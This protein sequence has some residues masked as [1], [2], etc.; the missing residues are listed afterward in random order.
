MKKAVSGALL[1]AC[2]VVFVIFSYRS[3]FN[4]SFS[5]VPEA[6]RA[7]FAM[8]TYMTIHCYGE[9]AEEAAAAAEEEIERIEALL[10]AKNEGSDISQEEIA[11]LIRKAL[12]L[13]EETKGAFDPTVYPLTKLWGF[14]HAPEESVERHRTAPS[15]EEIDQILP[16][17][18][19]E[20]VQ[21]SAEGQE[22]DLGG[23]AKG[24]TSDRIMKIFDEY[25]LTGGIVSLGGNVQCYKRKPDGRPWKVGIRLPQRPDPAGNG[26]GAETILGVLTTDACAVITSGSD[27][28][29]FIDEKTGKLW[30]HILDP[31]TGYPADND[32]LSV[33]IISREG[34]MADALSTACF[35]M[36][37]EEAIRFWKRHSDEFDLI[38]VC[39]DKEVLL[40]WPLR[41]KFELLDPSYE[42]KLLSSS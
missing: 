29:Y 30:H 33:T 36:G 12:Q 7:L 25:E 3:G 15:Q 10:S 35:V 5:A 22:L 39:K 42:L 37:K 38:L 11:A 24:Y 2:L 41:E 18:G 6:E 21:V 1:T 9:R 31:K 34:T 32:L 4:Q 19:W 28:R 17:I 13:S 27:Q 23:I 16:R 20:K 40:S 8:D 14:A 26:I